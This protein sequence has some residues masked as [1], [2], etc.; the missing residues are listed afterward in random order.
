MKVQSYFQ[1]YSFLVFISLIISF[2]AY[3]FLN[4]ITGKFIFLSKNYEVIVCPPC[5]K[6]LI[7]FL[8]STSY[9]L[10]IEM[11]VLTN[12]KV[13]KLLN[14]LAK[15]GIDIK[16]ILDEDVSENYRVIKLLDKGIKVKFGKED[17]NLTSYHI[18]LAIRDEKCI[19]IGTMNWNDWGLNSN[20]E[21]AVIICDEEIAKKLSETFRK[22]WLR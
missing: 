6:N 17:K 22:D 20:R 1:K 10:K 13:I 5:E 12:P 2:L 3:L 16:I 11:Y 21:I 18:K 14:R 7:N 9:S 15:R 4:S 19:W 8:N